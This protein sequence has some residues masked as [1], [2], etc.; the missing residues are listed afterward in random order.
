V[1]LERY[2]DVSKISYIGVSFF[3]IDGIKIPYDAHEVTKEEIQ[4][5]WLN[6]QNN[7]RKSKPKAYK[8]PTE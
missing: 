5:Y 6:Y 7:L 3:I 4:A 1:N 8:V 2:V